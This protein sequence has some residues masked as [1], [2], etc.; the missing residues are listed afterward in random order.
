MVALGEFCYFD[1]AYEEFGAEL[2]SI[3]GKALDDRAG[4]AV[5]LT[6]LQR[7]LPYDAYFVFTVQEEIGARGAVCAAYTVKPDIAVVIETTTACDIPGSDGEKQVC[8]LGGGA[9][10]TFMDRSTIYDRELYNAACAAA[11][12]AGVRHQSKTMIA[13]GND[14]GSIHKAVGGIRTAAVSVP[15]RYLH[16]PACVMRKE[17]VAAVLKTAEALL[18]GL[19][20]L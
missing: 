1:S 3:K 9:V 14:S 19:G 12:K 15:T 4:C 8:E 10:I 18:T 17:D 5:L 7:E 16:S 20:E 6:M 2:C 11:D 13:G